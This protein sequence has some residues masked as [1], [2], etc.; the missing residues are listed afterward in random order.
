ME[1]AQELFSILFP[2]SVARAILAGAF[3]P[4]LHGQLS[5]L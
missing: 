2:Y 3:V 5:L 1:P 4:V